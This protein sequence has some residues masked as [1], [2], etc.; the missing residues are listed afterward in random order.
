MR[1]SNSRLTSEA[2]CAS[3][4]PIN[5]DV[6]R[7]FQALAQSNPERNRCICGN[8]V[9]DDEQPLAEEVR[10]RD[11]WRG[12]DQLHEHSSTGEADHR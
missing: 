12:F 8:V 10:C 7:N 4:A 2:S 11:T 3:F 9:R 6:H 5:L 1:C